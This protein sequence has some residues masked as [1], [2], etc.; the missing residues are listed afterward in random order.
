MNILT[1]HLESIKTTR[2]HVIL[3][4]C[5]CHFLL[6]FDIYFYQQVQATHIHVR[7]QHFYNLHAVKKKTDYL[8]TIAHLTKS[9]YMM[10]PT[11]QFMYV[12]SFRF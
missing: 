10:V 4:L 8:T 3:S 11:I 5:F 2:L 7:I 1:S 12:K 9:V 6:V